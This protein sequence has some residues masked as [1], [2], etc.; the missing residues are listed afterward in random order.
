M[1]CWMISYQKC[2]YVLSGYFS[3]FMYISNEFW[4]MSDAIEDVDIFLQDVSG[5]SC[6]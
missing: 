3:F 4:A 1:A 2:G 6:T 5:F